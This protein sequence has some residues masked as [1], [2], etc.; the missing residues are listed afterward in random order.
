MTSLDTAPIKPAF[1]VGERIGETFSVL[2]QRFMTFVLLAAVPGIVVQLISLAAGL[3][4]GDEMFT[5]ETSAVAGTAS[6]VTIVFFAFLIPILVYSVMTGMMVMAAY[7]TKTGRSV[8]L[9][10]YVSAAIKRSPMLAIVTIIVT[11]GISIASVF[12]LV[13]G[14]WLAGVWS[15]CVP[16]V[17]ME[18]RGLGALSRSAEL[19][20][21][22]RWPLV[23]FVVVTYIIIMVITTLVTL[24][25]TVLPLPALVIAILMG[26]I[27]GVTTALLSIAVSV[28]YA[29]LRDIKEGVGYADLAEVFD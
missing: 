29:R 20:K 11:F 12:F 21:E 2:R 19:T 16:V 26:L 28:A 4:A 22:Y 13:P 15:V 27:N 18:S 6:I 7:D 24:A 23:G 9:G 5:D 10:A 17:M 8:R 14:L 1:G 3:G 25:F